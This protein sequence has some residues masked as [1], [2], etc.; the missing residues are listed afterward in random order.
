MPTPDS[1]VEKSDA[2]RDGYTA[3][4]DGGVVHDLLESDGRIEVTAL[5]LRRTAYE[6]VEDGHESQCGE[7]AEDP[8]VADG[9]LFIF[10]GWFELVVRGW[11]GI[12]CEGIGTY[13]GLNGVSSHYLFFDD[14]LRSRAV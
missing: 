3:P 10:R 14:E 8:F 6:D 7:E 1:Q 4:R 13:E 12:E 2:Y 11:D 5:A 9:S